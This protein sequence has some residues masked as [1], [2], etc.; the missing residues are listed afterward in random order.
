MKAGDGKWGAHAY[1]PYVEYARLQQMSM[2]GPRANKT[3]RPPSGCRRAIGLNEVTDAEGQAHRI[4][5]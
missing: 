1:R 4:M 2:N 5:K 3:I